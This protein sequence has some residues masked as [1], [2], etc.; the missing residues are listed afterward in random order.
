MHTD[1]WFPT[2]WNNQVCTVPSFTLTELISSNLT[3]SGLD[4]TLLHMTCTHNIDFKPFDTIRFGLYPPLHV[5]AMYTHMPYF[6]PFHT[7]R[8]GLYPPPC[9]MYIHVPYFQL[10]DK[11]RVWT[12]P[13]PTCH[14]HTYALLPAIWQNQVW[15]LPSPTCHAHIPRLCFERFFSEYSGII[16]SVFLDSGQHS[17]SPHKLENP[18]WSTNNKESVLYEL[19]VVIVIQEVEH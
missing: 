15:T 2:I 5:H 8:F 4:R 17:T 3:R 7:I 18:K 10:F 6:Q 12:L 1:D 13:S 11:I 19:N 9:A 14:V 16:A